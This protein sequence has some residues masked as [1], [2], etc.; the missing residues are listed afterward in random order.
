[1]V[2]SMRKVSYTLGE[3]SQVWQGYHFVLKAR[4]HLEDGPTSI[5]AKNEIFWLNEALF[6]LGWLICHY[7]CGWSHSPTPPKTRALRR[8]DLRQRALTGGLPHQLTLPGV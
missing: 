4:Q 5:V 2:Q 7:D 3:L 6:E 1:M 8:E